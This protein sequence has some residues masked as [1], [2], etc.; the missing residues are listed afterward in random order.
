[1]HHPVPMAI[2]KNVRGDERFVIERLSPH[3]VWEYP[4]PLIRLWVKP[5]FSFPPARP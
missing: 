3:P 4:I 5:L 2:L 1:M